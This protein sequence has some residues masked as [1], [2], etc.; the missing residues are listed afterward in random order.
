[1]PKF[2]WKGFTKKTRDTP[3]DAKPV[4]P[5]DGRVASDNNPPA[6]SPS[7]SVTQAVAKVPSKGV[8]VLPDD[9]PGHNRT[10]SNSATPYQTPTDFSSEATSAPPTDKVS[11]GS[12]PQ[13]SS[14]SATLSQVSKNLI[15]E[16]DAPAEGRPPKSNAPEEKG[17]EQS[18][19]SNSPSNTL[20]PV[21]VA[22][23]SLKAAA[24]KLEKAIPKEVLE[25]GKLE[26]K[27]CADINTLADNV[28]LAIGSLM[29][30]RNV[31]E[32]KQ[33]VVKTL[34]KGWVKKA[35]PFLQHGLSTTKAGLSAAS[36]LKLR[37]FC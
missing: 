17:P 15:S 29:N 20:T 27:G 10:S 16:A 28:A 35:L 24:K 12:N 1:M 8:P 18:D 9:G 25:S 21:E 6:S 14:N 33:S 5:P 22:E 26:I 37:V 30:E 34:L 3:D 2:K 36:V 31:A 32:S 19:R 11:I 7:A 4:L 13:A 23:A